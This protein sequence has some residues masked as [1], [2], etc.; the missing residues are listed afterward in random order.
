LIP[1]R[2][3]VALPAGLTGL[4]PSLWFVAGCVLLAAFAVGGYF[5]KGMS[6]AIVPFADFGRVAVVAMVLGTIARTIPE[7]SA[8]AMVWIAFLRPQWNDRF[9]WSAAG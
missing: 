6:G 4:R 7:L 9:L 2:T 8:I 1:E 3:V 5:S